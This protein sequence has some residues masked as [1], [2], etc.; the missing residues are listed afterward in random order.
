[1]A[2]RIEV[3]FY[4]LF[5]DA[6]LLRAKG[7]DP[8]NIRPASVPGSALRIGQQATLLPSPEGLAHGIL[9]QLTQAELE[10]PYS[11]S[12]VRA[13]RPEAV[14]FE[15]STGSVFLCFMLQSHR[16]ALP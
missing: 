9:M 13:Y 7:V 3:F 16:A 15:V 4:G 14:L 12:T 2:R 5:M 8:T 11:E 1:M 10:Q 6:D